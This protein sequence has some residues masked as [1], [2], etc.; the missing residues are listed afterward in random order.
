M[1]KVE[2]DLCWLCKHSS[3]SYSINYANFSNFS[4]LHRT[5][6][7]IRVGP[8]LQDFNLYNELAGCHSQYF[9]TLFD[10]H[11]SIGIFMETESRTTTLDDVP[12]HIRM[13]HCWLG[14]RTIDGFWEDLINLYILGGR[15]DVPKLSN[16][17]VNELYLMQVRNVNL[18]YEKMP[19]VNSV[20]WLRE[21]FDKLVP[22]VSCNTTTH[23]RPTPSEI[24]AYPVL[25][26]FSYS[27]ILLVEIG[28]EQRPLEKLQEESL[29]PV[30][31]NVTNIFR[32]AYSASI[33]SASIIE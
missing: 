12:V 14:T 2:T 31:I 5:L 11:S 33:L 20:R 3:S 29:Y 22:I 8:E 7:T 13:F 1:S 17:I 32:D 9:K 15:L 16:V 27:T 30:F 23:R 26:V 24:Q 4:E 10:R 18:L 25:D 21:M 28:Q 6:V 19:A